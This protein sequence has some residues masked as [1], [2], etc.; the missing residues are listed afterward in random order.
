MAYEVTKTATCKRC[1]STDVAWTQSVKTGKWY[2][3]EVFTEDGIQTT[4]KRDFH[5]AYCGKPEMHAVRQA[6]LDG[7]E[8]EDATQI[9]KEV[10]I[11]ALMVGYAPVQRRSQI[12]DMRAIA[13]HVRLTGEKTKADE[14]DSIADLC[15]D[16]IEELED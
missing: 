10:E 5:S 8:P 3:T 14:L 6:Q 16:F 13:A 11:L 7:P 9:A 12:D 4:S 15:E 2:L 1:K